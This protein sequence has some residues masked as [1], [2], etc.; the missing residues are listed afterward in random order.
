M[1]SHVTHLGH[2][3]QRPSQFAL[4]VPLNGEA[5]A[6]HN[7]VPFRCFPGTS[8]KHNSL[9]RDQ[10]VDNTNTECVYLCKIIIFNW[11]KRSW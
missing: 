6:G 7:G 9:A 11:L 5:P 1:F 8:K 4:R 2:L 10:Y 3:L